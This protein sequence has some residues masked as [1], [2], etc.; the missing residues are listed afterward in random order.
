MAKV[1]EFYTPDN[2]RRSMKWIS[3][4]RRG[5]ILAFSTANSPALPGAGEGEG[6]NDTGLEKVVL[7]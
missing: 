1:I 6:G 4:E 3:P 5:Q 7:P 2:F